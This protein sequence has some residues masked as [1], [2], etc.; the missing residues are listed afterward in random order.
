MKTEYKFEF[1]RDEANNHRLRVRMS[2]ASAPDQYRECFPSGVSEVLAN[3]KKYW[4]A[5][6]GSRVIIPFVT[7]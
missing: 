3:P 6:R 1:D 7:I 2:C 5:A 4:E